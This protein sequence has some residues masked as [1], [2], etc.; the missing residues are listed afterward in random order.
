[1]LETSRKRPHRLPASGLLLFTCLLSNVEA[2]GIV[3]TNKACYEY[4]EEILVTFHIDNPGEDDWIGIY[5]DGMV[6]GDLE[7]SMWV[8]LFQFI[9]IT[10]FT[11]I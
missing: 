2:D 7:P 5:P 3:S 11:V 10:L 8:S 4:D 6:N 9:R 1:M